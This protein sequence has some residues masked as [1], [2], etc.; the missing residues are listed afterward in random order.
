VSAEVEDSAVDLPDSWPLKHSTTQDRWSVLV[1]LG[2]VELRYLQAIKE[3]TQR[4][5]PQGWKVPGLPRYLRLT[6][7]KN[8]RRSRSIVLRR[9]DATASDAEHLTV[10]GL[11][12]PDVPDGSL[13]TIRAAGLSAFRRSRLAAQT[14][15]AKLISIAL[16]IFAAATTASF[17]IG[18]NQTEPLIHRFSPDVATFWQ[19][20]AAFAAAAAPLVGFGATEWWRDDV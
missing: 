10:N 9:A 4:D 2:R 20:L 12:A 1:P 15:R 14:T 13:V 19:V 18:R 16:G 8:G 17:A 6:W 3:S 5:P 11:V 7:T